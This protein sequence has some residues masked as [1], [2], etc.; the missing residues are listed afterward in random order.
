MRERDWRLLNGIKIFVDRK[1]PEGEMDDI[2]RQAEDVA[3]QLDVALPVVDFDGKADVVRE[4]G[5]E[6]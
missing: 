1:G 6:K 4:R 3:K 2:G 5:E